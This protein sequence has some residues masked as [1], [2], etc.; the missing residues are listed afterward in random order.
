MWEICVSVVD[1]QHIYN[2]KLYIIFFQTEVHDGSSDAALIKVDRKSTS[3]SNCGENGHNKR[4]CP[5]I[6]SSAPVSQINGTQLSE[7]K[8]G[9]K[10][11]LK[12]ID[13]L[14]GKKVESDSEDYNHVQ[15]EAN[16]T[17][18]DLAMS[19]LS[20][21][22]EHQAVLEGETSR[23]SSSRPAIMTKKLW[24]EDFSRLVGQHMPIEIRSSE[25]GRE[26]DGKKLPRAPGEGGRN[27]RR[28]HCMICRKNT[29]VC[30]E[31]CNTY[32]CI[33]ESVNK[34]WN[35]WKL[36]HTCKTIVD[37]D[38]VPVPKRLR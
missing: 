7:A 17:I 18:Y 26:E 37:S 3:C 34:G 31:Q 38:V 22:L 21:P 28:K 16:E 35:C 8:H 1:I 4:K 10:R 20:I 13:P 29:Y 15:Q 27:F 32:L 24:E 2:Q 36:F 11:K 33:K 23:L 6:N 30:C 12:S 19:A 25:E 9:K 5:V 14:S